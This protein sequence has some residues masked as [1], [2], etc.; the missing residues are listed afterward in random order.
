MATVMDAIKVGQ[1]IGMQ[2][3]SLLLVRRDD[4][5]GQLSVVWRSPIRVEVNHLGTSSLPLRRQESNI[6]H[7]DAINCA[8]QPS[9]CDSIK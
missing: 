5:E 1:P 2:G 7:A 8:N 9:I 6:L 3:S 4:D